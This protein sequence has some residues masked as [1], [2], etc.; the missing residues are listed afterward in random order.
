MADYGKLSNRKLGDQQAGARI[1]VEEH[2]R[3]PGG[4]SC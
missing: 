1:A 3:N 2:K 4:F